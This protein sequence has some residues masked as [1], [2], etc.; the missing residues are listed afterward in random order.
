MLFRRVGEF[1]ARHKYAIV[2]SWLALAVVL[3]VVVPQLEDVIKRDAT[4]FLPANAEVMH[5]YN[6][7]SQKF[8]GANA[9]GF[10]IAVLED[11]HGLTAADREFYA[12]AVDR[13]SR[14]GSR[15]VFVQDYL[16]HPEFKDAVQSKDGKA[17]YIPIGLRA[18]V[19]SPGA[20]AD[21]FWLRDLLKVGRPPGL[22]GYVTGD[23]AIIADYQKSINDSI[24][25]TTIITL[26][27]LIVILL[28]I[29]RSPVTPLIPLTTIGIAFM[30]VRPVVAFLGLHV[31][32]V[33]AFTETFILA[34]TFG[35]GTD[36]C[37]FLI[38]RF[39]EQ[40]A[41]GDQQV[42][43]I[44]TTSHRVGEAIT[45]SAA[46]VIVGGLAM[47]QANVSIF[48]TTGP[49]I[50]AAVAVTLVAGLTLTPAL[51]SIGGERFFWPQRVSVDKPSR[52]WTAASGLIVRRPRRVLLVALVPLLLLAAFYPGLRLTYDERQP[53]PSG[54][55]SI[56]GLRALDR[57]YTAGEV[58][59]DYILLQAD[60]DLRN[61]KDLANLDAATKALTRVPGVT[62]V[63][64]FTQPGG[65]RIPQASIAYQVGQVGAGLGQARDQVSGGAAGVQQLNQ[66]A[67]QLAD[68]AGR[69][70]AA[71][72][73]FLSGLG[74]ENSG[75]GQAASGSASA[76]SGAAQLRDGA[77][78]LAAGLHAAHNETQQAVDG[79]GMINTALLTDPTCQHLDPVCLKSQQGIAQIY[80]G[81]HD[82]L[83][84]GLQQA[85]Q[86][87]DSIAAG[88]A[89]LAVGL[90][91][92]HDGILQAQSGIQQLQAG[93]QVFQDKLGQLRGGAAQL[94][95]G[96]SQ[97]AGGTEQLKSGLD[98]ASSFLNSVSQQSAAAGLDTFFVPQDHIND[99][100]L[101]LA[102]YYFLSNDGT[103]A[104][105]AVLGRD[106]P[107]GIPAMDRVQK[108]KD[109]VRGAL[110]GTTLGNA[111]V[112]AAGFAA[113]ND[114]LRTLFKRD[115]TVVAIA[116]LLGVL[117]VLVLLLRSLVA[118]LY[119]LASVLL[120][121][122]AAM[123]FTTFFWQDLLGKGAID[124]TV[125]I[126]AFVM[127]VAVGADYN[128]FLMSRVREEV[129]RDPANG[130]GRAIRRTGAIITSA[131]IIFA[132]TF[133]AMISS[134]VLNIAETGF[135]ITFGLLLD[136]FIVRSFVVPAVAILLGRWNWWPHF[137]MSGQKVESL[138][139]TG[140]PEPS[141]RGSRP[142]IQP[143]K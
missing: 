78:L 103:T 8:S 87:A 129:L 48:S 64:S 16:A 116:V 115:F 37:I 15:V 128:I 126:F 90:A 127:L 41:R 12:T 137:G 139:H 82:Q 117:L 92:L 35:A 107:F 81:E 52:F 110:Q 106:D 62:Q 23:T 97:L 19:S 32:H 124:W 74:Q 140:R 113:Q 138:E 84:P 96:V 141:R 61:A 4:P 142:R 39:K 54:N 118:P 69:A 86:G 18:P 2:G 10:A 49:A 65:T 21:A 1:A 121:Y 33:A 58:L 68:G 80:T 38:S 79:L 134:P 111:R 63:R 131:G 77:A 7:M 125:P 36:Y 24:S 123:G 51:I 5:A 40:M 105:I 101:A 22:N 143:A 59:P 70:Q 73:Q 42:E 95:G 55:E 28:T 29:Y 130:I 71:V 102:R 13:I 83:L 132:G 67:A 14:G 94:S 133:A 119:L 85:A 93:E 76:L 98:Q 66:G 50:A 46:T 112:M 56:A 75:L 108:E 3:N 72:D 11:P 25:R 43:A 44:A 57:H 100:Q 109:A 34:L 17:L 120:S 135:A 45:S 30:V 6:V 136:T 27:L 26:I 20:D 88:T 104:R 9:Q 89:S 53:Q 122:A 60:H 31:I 91:Q 114:N 99:P 47:T